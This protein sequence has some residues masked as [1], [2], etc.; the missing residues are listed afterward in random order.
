ML[1]NSF[2]AA[3]AFGHHHMVR[4]HYIHGAQ[5][6]QQPLRDMDCIQ[7]LYCNAVALEDAGTLW[8]TDGLI[9]RGTW[10]RHLLSEKSS[11][12]TR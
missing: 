6:L 5:R 9:S 8:K 11:A 1:C 4:H 12:S 2:A 7:P 10:P 3:A